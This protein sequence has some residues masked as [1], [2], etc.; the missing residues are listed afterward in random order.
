[1][2]PPVELQN[3]A[4]VDPEEIGLG[5]DAIRVIVPE[6]A[7]LR[8]LAARF[9]DGNV[10][11]LVAALRALGVPTVDAA[12]L[13]SRIVANFSAI[14][15]GLES[16]GRLALLAWLGA[17]DAA[18]P[19]GAL[20]LDTV[21]VGEGDGEWVSPAT[22]IAPSWASPAP[23]NVPAISVARTVGVSQPVLRL[24]DQWCGLRDLDA[25]VGWVV[26]STRELPREDWPLAAKRLVRWLDE[27]AGQKGAEAVA[28]ACVTLRG[29]PPASVKSLRFNPQRTF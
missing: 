20:N 4:L 7:D 19:A 10:P 17:K 22:V 27:V 26:R 14:W 18:L 2:G 12:T 28:T 6:A 13:L 16:K 3:L 23:P 8:R 21:L 29:C 15:A 11:V 25:V 9:T 1:M 24:W 5:N